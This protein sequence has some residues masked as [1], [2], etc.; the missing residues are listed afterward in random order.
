MKLIL[1]LLGGGLQMAATLSIEEEKKHNTEQRIKLINQI[2]DLLQECKKKIDIDKNE[3]FQSLFNN[4]KDKDDF[5]E[6]IEKND[7]QPGFIYLAGIAR[8]CDF[9]IKRGSKED[10]EKSA[11]QAS[12]VELAQKLYRLTAEY[13]GLE[14]EVLPTEELKDSLELL[15]K[16]QED[17]VD[18]LAIILA[19]DR[20]PEQIIP[21][22]VIKIRENR[23]NSSLSVYAIDPI[24]YCADRTVA[25]ANSLKVSLTKSNGPQSA[26]AE[27]VSVN[28]CKLR[29]PIMTI[30]TKTPKYEAFYEKFK[31]ILSE[32]LK[33]EKRVVIGY[34]A[35]GCNIDPMIARLFNEL[36]KEQPDAKLFLDVWGGWSH[37]VCYQ[38]PFDYQSHYETYLKDRL[39]HGYEG[40]PLSLIKQEYPE[41]VLKGSSC[42]PLSS[43]PITD[44]VD[45]SLQED[46]SLSSSPSPI[47]MK[48]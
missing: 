15:D 27:N 18:I 9:L 2:F 3:E 33:K 5:L 16:F 39:E 12:D 40:I 6:H 14:E 24:I 46:P 48:K 23:P 43:V 30:F 32:K 1:I 31:K 47:K 34:H 26:K 29:F 28:L 21:D 38:E 10:K 41:L 17:Q 13:F 45:E 20:V 44:Q 22:W 25:R 4:S 7:L 37:R 36:K 35:A 42:E 8:F 19:P 11:T